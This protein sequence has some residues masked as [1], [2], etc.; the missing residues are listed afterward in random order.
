MKFVDGKQIA[1]NIKAERNRADIVIED[2]CKELNI[3]RPTY[4]SYEKD[5]S[6]VKTSTLIELAKMFNC[7]INM[8]FYTK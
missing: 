7:D 5:A 2:V 6:N 4:I 3:S 8:F 1:N